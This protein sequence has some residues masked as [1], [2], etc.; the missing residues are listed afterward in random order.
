MEPADH[1]MSQ[2]QE[3]NYVYKTQPLESEKYPENAG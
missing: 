3:G 1:E 2:M